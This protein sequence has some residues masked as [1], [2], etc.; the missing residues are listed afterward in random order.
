MFRMP[1]GMLIAV[2]VLA[3]SSLP[4]AGQGIEAEVTTQ[5]GARFWGTVTIEGN[6]VKLVD[7]SG[8]TR[9]FDL[10]S[11]TITRR[12]EL[13]RTFERWLDDIEDEGDDVDDYLEL[14]NW[15]KEHGLY[16]QTQQVARTIL[17]DKPDN[18]TA[19]LA[20]DWARE[21]LRAGLQPL[22]KQ[23]TRTTGLVLLSESDIQKIRFALFDTRAAADRVLVKFNN[24]VLQ[25]FLQDVANEQGFQ[26]LAE[27]RAF[28]RLPPHEQ[29]RTIKEMTGNK[30]QRDIEIR[31]DPLAITRFRRWVMPVV[32]RSCAT[33]QCH[34]S[35]KTEFQLH[36][37]R[38]LSLAA[39]YSNFYIMDTHQSSAGRLIDRARPQDSLLL[40]YTLGK[41]VAAQRGVRRVITTE[42]PG[43]IAPAFRSPNDRRYQQLLSWIESLEPTQPDYGLS[44]RRQRRAPP[45][46]APAGAPRGR[47]LQPPGR[48]RRPPPRQY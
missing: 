21:Q 31:T 19:K 3:C 45:T 16:E 33:V 10:N 23:P 13:L 20:L 43:Q 6:Q 5:E 14:L 37:G 9:T 30:Y 48:S 46:T 29:L 7:K 34:G 39:L 17:K 35:D 25:R 12:A 2:T 42:H 11:V 36:S 4:A 8:I 18:P 24:D 26:T 38:R 32:S 41:A 22:T 1:M 15:C 40:R 27:Q 44:L 47:T 28:L